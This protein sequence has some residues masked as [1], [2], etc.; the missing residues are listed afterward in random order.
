MTS[1]LLFGFLEGQGA[2]DYYADRGGVKVFAASSSHR[3]RER[4]SA[5]A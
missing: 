3:R 5:A 2:P 4:A 1:I